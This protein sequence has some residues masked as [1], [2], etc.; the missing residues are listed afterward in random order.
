[1]LWIGPR[2]VSSNMRWG[3]F[4]PLGWKSNRVLIHHRQPS[5]LMPSSRMGFLIHVA[6]LEG[7]KSPSILVSTLQAVF[8]FEIHLV[9]AAKTPFKI[10]P[11]HHVVIFSF[12]P[13][14]SVAHHSNA[15]LTQA[16]F[17][18]KFYAFLWMTLRR[19]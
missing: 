14:N 1:M 7:E 12:L 3:I 5:S 9:Q 8:V 11:K 6:N 4:F 10:L 15:K 13:R 16:E 18:S 17:F 19:H 2:F